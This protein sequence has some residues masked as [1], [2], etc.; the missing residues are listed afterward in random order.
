MAEDGSTISTV[1]TVMGKFKSFPGD[2][3][4]GRGWYI[5]T[6]MSLLTPLQAALSASEPALPA[7]EA[8]ARAN[9]NAG[10]NVYLTLDRERVL[11]EA[12][13]L[14]GR[15]PE[16]AERPPLYGVPVGVKDCFD[17][18]GYL[19]TCG[20]HFYATKN[21]IA[22]ADSTVAKRLRQAGA[23]IMGKTHLHQLA[24]GITGENSE[25]GDCAQ[26]ENPQAL[27]GGSS[28]GSAASVQEGSA[29]ASIGTDTGGSIRA[30]SALCGLAGYRST[31]GLGGAQAWVGGFHL[32]RSFDTLGW[33][34]RDLRDG[35]ALA[36]ALLDV[37]VVAAPQGV[38]IGAVGEAYL[39]DCEPAV[40]EMY[41]G[42]QTVLHRNGAEIRVVEPDFWTDSREIFGGIQAH[43]AAAVHRGYFEHFE[44]W[45][46]DRLT[47]GASL[48]A[49]TVEELRNRHVAFRRQMDRLLQVHDFLMLPCAPMSTMPV[50]AD[51]SAARLKILRYTTPVSLAGMPAVTLAAKGGGVQLV[52]A[53]GKDAPLL[54][55]AA[56]LGEKIALRQ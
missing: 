26:P 11:A 20:S 12:E 22:S 6:D 9:S 7:Q 41:R 28:S 5:Q 1:S 3:C 8:L 19:T 17:V 43:E 39:H 36:A 53:R 48:T 51:H 38:T 42:W 18:A 34:F 23:V 37:P 50:G 52:A 15:F 13:A 27:T 45:I 47:W 2:R 56:G 55:F 25:Y 33:L 30:P 14:P 29:V 49:G 46:R 40:L 54:A 10:R 44:P 16:P 21:G 4:A 31:L 32:A 24:Y 35:P